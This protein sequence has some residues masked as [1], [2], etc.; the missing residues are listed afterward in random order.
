[1]TLATRTLCNAR[2]LRLLP[3]TRRLFATTLSPPLAALATR[4]GRAHPCIPLNAGGIRVLQAP[5][6]F[7]AALLAMIRRARSHVFLSSLYMG[8]GTEEL[9]ASLRAALESNRALTVRI[10]LDLLRSTRPGDTGSIRALASLSQE[11]PDRMHVYLFRSPKLKGTL[12]KL[13]PRRFDEGWGTWHA[14]MYGAD[15]EVMLSGANLS[16]SYF[17]N[18]QDRYIHLTG[19]A[20]L[21]RYCGAFLRVFEQFS[22]I[23][24]PSPGPDG[25]EIAWGNASH[26][27]QHIESALRRA[28]LGLQASQ[29]SAFAATDQVTDTLVVP[30]VQCGYL[31]IRHEE[32]SMAALFDHVAASQSDV[33]LTSGYFGLY[34]PYQDLIVNSPSNC[35]IANG[36]YGSAGVSG[37]IPAG[38]TL[39]EQRFWSRVRSSGRAW[40]GDS[41]VQ[42]SEWERPGWTY[43]AKG[44]WLSPS[45]TG[46]PNVSLF[47]STNLSSRSAHLDSELSFALL[48]ENDELRHRLRDE[49]SSIRS[50]SLVVDESTW[51]ALSR[52]VGLTTKLLVAL[53]QDML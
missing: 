6:D 25:Y 17:T 48:T 1:M 39:L 3:G 51:K 14:K 42:L 26:N 29:H 5:N 13:V 15:D 36:F 35:R 21:V 4:L 40:S 16:S 37:H 27:P 33:D 20:A 45:S 47:G 24:R 41:G 9:L 53:V 2:R 50:H 30:A 18:R 31:G 46:L 12:A 34:R 8:S 32:D 19:A 49:L 10:H 52:R 43:H 22:F 44:M 11:F 38:Y 23:L 28:L 7:Y